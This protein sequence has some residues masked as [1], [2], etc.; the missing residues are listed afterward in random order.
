MQAL[1]E[2]YGLNFEDLRSIMVKYRAIASGSSVLSVYTDNSFTPNDIDIWVRLPGKSLD[3]IFP[4]YKD[5][6][7]YFARH[8]FDDEEINKKENVNEVGRYAASIPNG[9]NRIIKVIEFKNPDK[10][11]KVQFI[12]LHGCTPIDFIKTNFDIS[13]CQTWWDPEKNV[14]D[15]VDPYH[16][17][18]MKMYITYDKPLDKLHIKNKERVE[19]YKSRGFELINKPLPVLK[20]KEV[21]VFTKDF[22]FEIT[23]IIYLEETDI[24]SYLLESD[25]NIV[26]KNGENYYGFVRDDLMKHLKFHLGYE[27]TI[28]I[29]KQ[30][31]KKEDVNLFKY[32]DY[33]IYKIKTTG[34]K[35]KDRNYTLHSVK[36]MTIKEFETIYSE[37]GKK[38]GTVTRKYPDGKIKNFCSYK[39]NTRTSLKCKYSYYPDG[40]ILSQSCYNEENKLHGITILYGK[41]GLEKILETYENGIKTGITK[42]FY[43]NGNVK[44]EITYDKG[45]KHGVINEYDESGKLI[46][47]KLYKEDK[48]VQIVEDII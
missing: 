37:N 44:S 4:I 1:I 28:T 6:L 45:L 36:P 3:Y 39:D 41:D 24:K 2:S 33:S 46:K 47:S 25:K 26:I 38:N 7:K 20:E 8:G 19:K 23:D 21:R 32:S 14:I 9:L 31:I 43:E 35:T 18:K 11:K 12:L 34:I 10:T 42:I 13:V 15:S 30:A 40:T 27:Y 17:K 29:M 22:N 16:T 48:L 5:L